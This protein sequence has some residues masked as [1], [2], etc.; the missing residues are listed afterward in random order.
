MD[1]VLYGEAPVLEARI[2]DKKNLTPGRYMRDKVTLPYDDKD[3]LKHYAV[4]FLH[5]SRE[6]IVSIINGKHPLIKNQGRTYRAYF[7]DFKPV[8]TIVDSA[9]KILPVTTTAQ[10]KK[11]RAIIY[12]ELKEL[13]DNIKTPVNLVS[14]QGKNIIYD[15]QPYMDQVISHPKVKKFSMLQK[16][17]TFF[18]TLEKIVRVTEAGASA[19]TF[20]PIMINLEEYAKQTS[21]NQFHFVTYFL[22]IMRKSQKYIDNYKLNAN[23]I[24]YSSRGYML[25]DMSDDLD[26]SILATFRMGLKKLAPNI[27]VEKTE[28]MIEKED[29]ALQVN[30]K[31]AVAL[32]GDT[33]SLPIN[34]DSEVV[35]KIVDAIA[36][37]DDKDLYG[38]V[39]EDDED[40][41]EEEKEGKKLSD[42]LSDEENVEVKVEL[43]KSLSTRYS[44]GEKVVSK[45]DQLLR[46]KQRKLQIHGKTFEELTQDIE[47]PE[48]PEIKID[49]EMAGT[50]VDCMKSA[51]FINFNKTYDKELRDRDIA[52][53]FTM[54]N[55]KSINMNVLSIES[56]D[57]SDALNM[58]ETYTVTYEDEL[59]RRHTVKVNMPTFIDDNLLYINGNFVTIQNQ[60]AGLPVIKTGP[61]EVQICSNYNKIWNQ[62]AGTKFNPNMER[63]K[64]FLIKDETHKIKVTK[65]DNSL[66]NKKKLTCLEYDELAKYYT[67]V[68]IEDC[69]FVF[70]V[71]E[72]ESDLPGKESSLD[73]YLIG[74]RKTKNG[75][76]PLWYNK[77][78]NENVD[79]ISTMIQ[80]AIPSYYSEFK[81]LSAGKKYIYTNTKI[82]EKWIPMVVVACFFEGI[83]EVVRKFN[84]PRVSFVDEK[85]K[86][87]NF[88][89]VQFKDGYLQYPMSDMEACLMFNGLS[90]INTAAYSVADLDDRQTYID[91]F[92]ELVGN[93]FIAGGLINFYDFMMDP[94]TVELCQSLGYPTDLVSLMIYANNLLAD[95][96]YNNDISLKNYR[97][98]RNE[99]P[100]VILYK[101]LAIAYSRYRASARNNNPTKISVDPDCVI[102]SLQKV[103][104]VGDYSKMGPIVE[105]RDR[106]FASMRGYAGMNLDDA[107]NQEK[108]QYD[109]DS[110]N[111]IIGA[112]TDNASNCGKERHM[113]LEPNIVNA[114]GMYKI[115]GKED[116]NSL[117]M[118]QMA[119]GLELMNPGGLLHDDPVRTA[120]A[121]KQRGHAVPVRKACPLLVDTGISTTIHYRTGNDY[122]VAA[123]D[124]G[125][126]EMKDDNLGLMTVKYKDG[127]RQVIDISMKLAKAGG[128]GIYLRNKLSTTFKQG[129]K[130]KKDAILAFDKNFYKDAGFMGNR[131]QFGALA[132]SMIMSDSDT[133]ED[134]QWFTKKFSHDAALESTEKKTVTV[135]KNATVEFVRKP[136]EHVQVG[137]ELMR[138]DTSYDDKE[139]NRL[140]A[141][142]RG[143]LQETI[144]DLGKTKIHS[145]VDGVIDKVLVYPAAPLDEL[146]PSLKKY[147]KEY[148]AVDK[149]RLAYMDKIDPEH[150]GSVYRM[151]CLLNNPVG[152]I[153]PDPFG[154]IK[155]QDATDSVVFEFYITFVDELSDGDKLVHQNANKATLS[156]MVPEGYE[157]YSEFRPYEEVSVI[158]APSAILQRGTP[159]IEPTMLFYKA[160]IEL[161]RKHYKML[162]GEDW[163]EKQKRDNPYMNHDKL[164][165]K[166][167][168]STEIP[169]DTDKQDRIGWLLESYGISWNG[170][171]G[172]SNQMYETGDVVV[173]CIEGDI[174]TAEDV[175][176][177]LKTDGVIKNIVVD[178]MNN[179]IVATENIYPT[180]PLSV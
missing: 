93:G 36:D 47:I 115:T 108:R 75:K 17:D 146:S 170:Q 48:I 134:S 79:L 172:Y 70:N 130:F 3:R 120:M 133:Y 73:K 12:A 125:V 72:L 154:K 124:D 89:Y 105:L 137:D 106:G 14:W 68:E 58:K 173:E 149:Q 18:V 88:I 40:D 101:Q 136:G 138:F 144:I 9:T 23:I 176:R 50:S 141:G 33:D 98:R 114:R 177:Y 152:Q 94:I 80:Y 69:V 52:N 64:K 160:L 155:G 121:T 54:Y 90:L 122:S 44:G 128:E 86:D 148:Q 63:F 87:D 61:D 24:L 99:I 66:P 118:E 1:L 151:E 113:V 91:V 153:S 67:V 142:V 131:L 167:S 20:A 62:R 110:M 103:V 175:G 39:D 30:Q 111:G 150:K 19:Y 6:S 71:D 26:K 107:Y 81:K 162:T 156:S 119:T 82:M 13:D 163:N 25:I 84:D 22:A 4:P 74:Y 11:D 8:R 126:V 117:S 139:L 92:E 37:K 5:T 57:T 132:K 127:S 143:D 168:E 169:V 166:V 55:D 32:T 59:R 95:N 34:P 164:F 78:N 21:I 28:E 171:A 104:T 60:I 178:S 112:S 51:R 7:Y 116:V 159:S 100:Q 102:K 174:V 31:I 109:K 77:N 180:E 38:G 27:N 29:I 135:G 43:A 123:K 46:E 2:L 97:N 49:S 10:T 147:V 65:G 15:Y 42:V 76:E 83:T 145:K 140:L 35:T 53:T 56:E 179:R 45:R 165:E 96:Q 157:P 161:K 85:G 129:D 16:V 41:D 158:I